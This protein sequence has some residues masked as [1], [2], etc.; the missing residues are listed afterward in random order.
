MRAWWSILIGVAL[1]VALLAAGGA[2]AESSGLNA[3]V[4]QSNLLLAQAGDDYIRGQVTNSLKGY[5]VAGVDVT[6]SAEITK[7]IDF[8]TTDANGN[9]EFTNIQITDQLYMI[10][11]T[12]REYIPGTLRNVATGT[13][14]ANLALVP[15][16]VTTPR[17]VLTYSGPKSVY[18]EWDANPEYNLK[19]YYVWRT[20]TDVDGNA[21]GA[22]QKITDLLP[23][24]THPEY[25]DGA[26]QAGTYY[27]YQIQ[28]LSAADRESQLSKA[29]APPV[30][31][32]FL[33]VF[34]PDVSVQRNLSGMMLWDLTP[35]DLT[36]NSQVRLPVSTE[37]AYQVDA[38]GMD[39]VADLPNNLIKA[40][41]R[42]D[43]QVLP[44]GITEG[45][46]FNYNI[47]NPTPTTSELRISSADVVSRS[48]YGTGVL[49]DVY[50]QIREESGCG[51]LTLV[52]DQFDQGGRQGVR[53]YDI[54]PLPIELELRNAELCV[55]TSP[56]V[57][58]DVDENRAI[59][60]ADAQ[61]VTDLKVAAKSA[62]ELGLE[63]YPW[64]ADIN[65]DR[66]VDS[67]DASM[68]LQWA[69]NGTLNPPPSQGKSAAARKS[70]AYAAWDEKDSAPTVS[71][72]AANGGPGQIIS[73]PITI[74]EE[75]DLPLA[76]FSASVAYPAGA[77]GLVFQSCELGS[78][79]E[80]QFTLS[81]ENT[82]ENQ[83]FGTVQL[84][85]SNDVE[86]AAKSSV[87][88]ATLTFQVGAEA[89]AGPFEVRIKSFES[90]DPFGYTPRHG[91]PGQAVIKQLTQHELTV[92][93]VGQGTTTPAAG[94][95]TYD[96]GAVVPLTAT[97]A[98]GWHF[99]HWSGP[100]ASEHVPATTVTLNADVTVT[101][102]FEMDVQEHTLT[103][104]PPTG[105]GTTTP[106]TGNHTYNMGA[107]VSVTA[108]PAS[109]WLFDHWT[110]PVAN[111]NSATTTITMNDDATVAAVFVQQQYTLTIAVTGQG[112]TT[113]AAGTQS[114]VAGTVVQLTAAPAQDWRFKEWTG[115]VADPASAN[116]SVTVD[117]NITVTAVFTDE[118][119][120]AFLWC[121]AGSGNAQGSGLG[122]LAVV[123]LMILALTA[124]PGLRRR[125]AR[126]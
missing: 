54:T 91:A 59:N 74:T 39:I 18:I 63:C 88:L 94:T 49:F 77:D 73:V 104:A 118:K 117:G 8:T 3:L 22:A 78:E 43:I 86:L 115:P 24:D 65:Q 76:G 105:Q 58:G 68:I 13:N 70:Y 23:A 11:F 60:G 45:M 55:D 69:K 109:G 82:V 36:D 64:S 85:A 110:G 87:T 61:L 112:T 50:A 41:A 4:V 125:L 26:V 89:S 34:F 47:V 32:Q 42:A 48:L 122:D 114:Y 16:G 37:C 106:A 40:D 17:N 90:N 38:A 99:A 107:V 7:Q 10:S 98:T 72:G 92:V 51:G 29:S 33:T 30:K 102:I 44:T 119:E 123:G 31:G 27:V 67:A 66:R 96:L 9:Y 80:G 111:A 101:A 35:E 108:T 46:T 103:V 124:A 71:I 97:P 56:C 21:L 52:E 95:H 81:F 83:W 25:T 79:L 120:N 53:M 116:T 75:D 113:P 121:A 15:V 12:K 5:P 6:L 100:V 28:A 126:D 14:G 93:V 57:H 2:S 62:D 84:S 19:G 1:G 20:V